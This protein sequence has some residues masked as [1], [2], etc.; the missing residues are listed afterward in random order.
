MSD[1]MTV[2]IDRS[3]R[4]VVPKAI[5]EEAGIEAGEPLRISVRDG[6]IEIVPE[7]VEV[8]IV[9]RDGFA[10]AERVTPG[11]TLSHETVRRTLRQVR[12]RRRR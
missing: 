11:P 3:G 7:Y 8:R 4:L 10:V 2:T 1:A 5:R 6:R 12:D 9:E